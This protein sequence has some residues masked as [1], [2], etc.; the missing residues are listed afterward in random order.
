MWNGIGIY[1]ERFIPNLSWRDRF[2][3][4]YYS[5]IYIYTYLIYIY[6]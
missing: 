5:Y 3:V 4:E 2:L 1:P 6:N